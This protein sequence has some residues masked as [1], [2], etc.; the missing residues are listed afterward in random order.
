MIS[1]GLDMILDF[2]I[3]SISRVAAYFKLVFGAN[4]PHGSGC[5][6]R[7]VPVVY[8]WKFECIPKDTANVHPSSD[9]ALAPTTRGAVDPPMD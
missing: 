6:V 3:C 7:K 5:Q 1:F 2:S 4:G 8:G 9:H